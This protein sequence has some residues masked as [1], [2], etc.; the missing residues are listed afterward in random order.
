MVQTIWKYRV[1]DFNSIGGSALKVG[2]VKVSTI[3]LARLALE[4]E[5][6]E[7]YLENLKKITLI[8]L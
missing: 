1:F 3:N 6:Q 8:D 5:T 4:S 2:S 7:D